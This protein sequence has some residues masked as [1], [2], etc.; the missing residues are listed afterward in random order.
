VKEVL[1]W[2]ALDVNAAIDGGMTALHLAV[3][4]QGPIEVVQMLLAAGADVNAA[5]DEGVSVLQFAVD[6]SA[7]PKVLD[8]LLNAGA[9]TS[10]GPCVNL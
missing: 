6:A 3:G 10:P 5:T 9:K 1:E 4:E 2:G 8:V 7:D